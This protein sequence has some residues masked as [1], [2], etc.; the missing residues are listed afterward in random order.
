MNKIALSIIAVATLI[1][2]GIIFSGGTKTEVTDGNNV[3]IKDGI[4]YVT[5][6]AKGGYRPAVSLAQAGIP[7][8]LVVNTKGTFDCS[9]SLVIN[10]LNYKKILPQ[11]GETEIDVGVPVADEP[12]V[13]VCSMGMYNFQVKFN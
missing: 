5:I 12:L 11:N 6:T 1:F 7:T 10:S 4:Q 3:E 13:G 9:A 8:K 2:L